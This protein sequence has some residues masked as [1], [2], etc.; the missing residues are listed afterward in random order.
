MVTNEGVFEHIGEKRAL[1]NNMLRSNT[2]WT[3]HILEKNFL[4]RD[5]IQG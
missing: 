2:N 5:A 4:H 3:R 1:L